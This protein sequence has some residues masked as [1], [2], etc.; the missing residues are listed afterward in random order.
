M[1]PL[2]LTGRAEQVIDGTTQIVEQFLG[3]RWSD[4]TIT[5][6]VSLV[7]EDDTIA[8]QI[9]SKPTSKDTNP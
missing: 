4:E 9:L 1:A 5:V 6:A 2:V 7:E 3:R 8:I